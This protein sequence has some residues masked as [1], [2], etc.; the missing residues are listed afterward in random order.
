METTINTDLFLGERLN[1]FKDSIP[2]QLESQT[3]KKA[4]ELRNNL[5]NKKS[6]P[7]FEL[8]TY[9]SEILTWGRMHKRNKE[10][11]ESKNSTNW[12]HLVKEILNGDV[13]RKEAF[14][15]FQNL[16][17]NKDLNGMGIAYFTKLIFFLMPDNLPRGYIMDQWVACSINVLYGKDEVIMNSSHTPKIYTKNNF[18]ENISVGDIIK[19]SNYIVSDLNDANVYERYCLKI[20]E[21]S[22]IIGQ[23][24]CTTELLLMSSGGRKPDNWRNYV[25]EKRIPFESI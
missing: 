17:S 3:F 22:N 23:S 1:Y 7:D 10:I 14:S 15:R 4:L 13:N 21:L 20:E 8:I 18:E 2:L 9:C 24:A 12:Q 19:M 25:I 5:F 16:R 11:F 6:E